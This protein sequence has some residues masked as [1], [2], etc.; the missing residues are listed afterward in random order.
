[1]HDFIGLHGGYSL[2]QKWLNSKFTPNGK[3]QERTPSFTLAVKGLKELRQEICHS[4]TVGTATKGP[5]VY[6][7]PGGGGFKKE[8]CI[9][10]SPAQKEKNIYCNFSQLP[11]SNNLLVYSVVC[12]CRL[13]LLF[14]W[15]GIC[16]E[17]DVD[18]I[19]V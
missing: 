9:K 11:L 3:P 15:L 10:T 13:F 5:I 6:Y 1:M 17:V 7:V 2:C 12:L 19:I 18:R 4:Q 16:V 14:L 8:W